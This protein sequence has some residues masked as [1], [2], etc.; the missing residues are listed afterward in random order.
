MSL[1][2][3]FL[4]HVSLAGTRHLIATPRKNG[5]NQYY[6]YNGRLLFGSKML[7][8]PALTKEVSASQS[9]YDSRQNEYLKNGWLNANG[10]IRLL[11]YKRLPS[12][13]TKV[14]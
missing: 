6:F 14:K 8:Q 5:C 7:P 1:K 3:S 13:V 9:H 2:I 4:H 12:G 10:L 11:Q